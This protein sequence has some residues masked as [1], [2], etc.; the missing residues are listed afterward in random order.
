MD[1]VKQTSRRKPSA[2]FEMRF[3][4]P[5]MKPWVVPMRA[6]A[7]AL[8]AVQRLMEPGDEELQA[9]DKGEEELAVGT[10]PLHLIDVVSRSAAY[11]VS[12]Y[13]PGQAI[14]T[15]ERT[16]QILRSPDAEEWEPEVL[17]PI[18]ELS[19][20]AKSLHCTIEFKKPGKDGA[21]LATITPQS[22]GTLAM[23]AF[24]EGETSVYGFLERVGGATEQRCGLRLPTQ[25][26]RMIYCTVHTEEM[27]RKLG[28]HI[29]ENIL[30]SGTVTWFR[31]NG[32]VKHI[33]V[34]NFE[35]S[36][37]GSILQ[38]LDRIYE[39]GGKAWDEVEDPEGLI[40]ETRGS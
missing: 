37:R 29:Y 11:S 35:T 1:R 10:A 6:L 25:P 20:I 36:K 40:A 18:E 15:L 2:D 26:R 30:V 14:A 16:G 22:Y 9:E 23:T 4:G 39:A 38:A 17:A 3:K 28:E 33:L 5:G 34:N 13:D 27:V 32:R 8:Y 19:G 31:S 24:M 7:R 12:A 21:I